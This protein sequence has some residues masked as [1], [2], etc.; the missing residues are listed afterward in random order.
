ML[1][2]LYP[3]PPYGFQPPPPHYMGVQGY[4]NEFYPQPGPGFYPSHSRKDMSPSGAN[5]ANLPP[6]EVAKTIPC[7]NF[8][9]C[10]YGSACAFYHPG[11]FY[12]AG[13]GYYDG[14]QQQQQNGF[15][16]QQ[17]GMPMPGPYFVPNGFGYPDPNINQHQQ[18]DQQQQQ[19]PDNDNIPA[20]N[21]TQNDQ[22]SAPVPS[23]S[24]PSAV[25]PIF[26]PMGM[27]IA[28]P[29]PPSQFGL[30]PMSPSM[31]AG[32]LPS[33][34]PAEAFFAGPGSPPSHM[35][36]PPNPFIPNGH[37][38]THSFS[39][40]QQLPQAFVMP[41]KMYTGKKPSFSGGPRPFNPRASMG[42]MGGSGAGAN[43][44][45]WKD[46]VPPPCAFFVQ[47]KCRNGELCK[48]PHIDEQ[49]NDCEF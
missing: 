26:V 40:Q 10:K 36:S 24:V 17:G 35:M 46:G 3:Q 21:D 9:N 32:S 30:S 42:G 16:Y 38:R 6:V 12:P 31:L 5:G 33:I 49:G 11:A 7:R 28:S 4:S 14:P 18:I 29:P 44:G 22:P 1:S 34:P 25:A 45:A 27:N 47:G 13:P 41:N 8:P 48:F 43:L 37:V 39:Q 15:T 23:Q 19:R 20:S 2:I